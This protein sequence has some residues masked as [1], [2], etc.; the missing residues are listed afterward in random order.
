MLKNNYF[1]KFDR[2]FL[3]YVVFLAF[4]STVFLYSKHT[5][6]ND[7][8]ISEW[9]INYQ[10]GF[11]RRGII[12]EI[13]F[14]LADFFKISLRSVIFIF[15]ITAY[16]FYF[17][18]IYLFFKKIKHNVITLFAIFTPIFLLYPVAEVEA[19]G[20]KEVFLYIYFLG[21][22]FLTNTNSNYKRYSN[23]YIIFVTPIICLVY[24]QIIHFFPFLV[25]IIVFQRK[26]KNI[27]SFLNV[28]LLFLP[29]ILIIC[30]FF[31]K[32]LGEDSHLLMEKSLLDNFNEVCY[33]SCNLLN[34]ND[35]NKFG[36]LIKYIYGG[37][38]NIEI[39]TWI[40][41]YLIIIL[42]GFFPLYFLSIHSKIKEENIFS[43]FHLSNIFLLILFLSLTIIPLYI[44]GGD[45]G[46]WTGMLITFSTIFYFYLY[47]FNYIILDHERMNKKLKF[48]K[49]KK[50]FTIF[51]FIIFAFG[52]NQKTLMKGD[53]ATNPLWKVPYNTSKK[54]FGFES[55][56][57]FQE[58]PILIWHKKYIE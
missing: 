29:S 8:S 57:L 1:D 34:K 12:G 13:C 22:L 21:F 48:F 46:R 19:L 32:P 17:F 27:Y 33:M 55:F 25:A 56:K 15:Q 5:V 28:C 16:L 23:L 11:T 47:K 50:K 40:F 54:I 3:F 9:L 35:L 51:I 4:C 41:R 14:H 44:F 26:I 53:V 6:G 18:L 52:W 42:I 10:G 31:I 36:D 49:N 20:R 37:F 30:Y 39:M 43:N 7:T 38:S 24:E 2:Y 58:S 45:W